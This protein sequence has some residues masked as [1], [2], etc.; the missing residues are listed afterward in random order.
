MPPTDDAHARLDAAKAGYE[1][2]RSD[3]NRLKTP[4]TK[5]ARE[6]AV[7]ELQL[8]ARKLAEIVG[9]EFGL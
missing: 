9:R 4:A 8:A 3:D 6:A 7:V 2:A 5:Q 1:K